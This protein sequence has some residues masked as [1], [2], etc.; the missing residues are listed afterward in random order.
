MIGA[1]DIGGTK[2]A[3]GVVDHGGRVLA[4]LEQPTAPDAGSKTRWRE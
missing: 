2:I 4:K 3:A 1:I